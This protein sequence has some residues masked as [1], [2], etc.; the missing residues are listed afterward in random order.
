MAR[1]SKEEMEVVGRKEP[2]EVVVDTTA[3]VVA[4]RLY[5]ANWNH[6]IVLIH[7][8][9]GCATNIGNNG[10]FWVWM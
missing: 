9:L 10:I 5:L 6:A 3:V 2:V 4:T 7:Q 8:R 1:D